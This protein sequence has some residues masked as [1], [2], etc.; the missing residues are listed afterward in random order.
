MDI[1]TG[2]LFKNGAMF[3]FGNSEIKVRHE[4][5]ASP[6]SNNRLKIRFSFCT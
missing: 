1:D 6:T 2:S 4:L 5:I 3:F